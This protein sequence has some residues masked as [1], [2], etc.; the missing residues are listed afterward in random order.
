MRQESRFCNFNN[1]NLSFSPEM[2]L[3]APL[4]LSIFRNNIIYLLFLIPWENTNSTYLSNIVYA[5]SRPIK[6]GE[7]IKGHKILLQERVKNAEPLV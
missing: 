1:S 5:I 7:T 2:R 3:S 6:L 4:P